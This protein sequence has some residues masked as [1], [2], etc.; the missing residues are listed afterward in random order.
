MPRRSSA[1]YRVRLLRRHSDRQFHA[2]RAAQRDAD[3]HFTP[4]I[5][6]LGGAAKVYTEAERRRFKRRYFRRNPLG[7]RHRFGEYYA[8]FL[9]H[10][11]WWSERLGLKQPLKIIYRRMI[12]DP[13]V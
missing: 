9:D 4:L 10:V 12:G 7:Y 3:P 5:A 2:H 8:A 13:V 6:K 11:R 1:D